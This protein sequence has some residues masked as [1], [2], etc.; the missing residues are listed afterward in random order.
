MNQKFYEK[1]WFLWATLIFFAPVGIF[2]LWKNKK[3]NKN[4]TIIL[5]AIFG[6]WFIIALANGG[7]TK[8]PQETAV[9]NAQ[10][11][12]QVEAPIKREEPKKEVQQEEK[13]VEYDLVSTKKGQGYNSFYIVVQNIDKDSLKSI[14][15]EFKSKYPQKA[16]ASG[17]Q[18]GF[19]L[20]DN[21]SD[22][23]NQDFTTSKAM[24]HENYNNG[25]SELYIK[26][27]DETIEVK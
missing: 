9:A 25:L 13:N 1:D 14:I 3:F 18:I 22:A 4:M 23:T 16:L 26:D 20:S 17:F 27:T 12:K 7:K 5:T 19:F 10:E 8:E 2:L 6:I 21:K 24:Y 11:T 15:K